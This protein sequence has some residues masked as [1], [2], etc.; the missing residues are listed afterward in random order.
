MSGERGRAWEQELPLEGVTEV[1]R[2][3]GQSEGRAEETLHC[4]GKAPHQQSREG[5]GL[6][7]VPGQADPGPG[8]CRNH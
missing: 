1:G 3:R 7:G 6:F 4:R 2:M 8:A 5:A